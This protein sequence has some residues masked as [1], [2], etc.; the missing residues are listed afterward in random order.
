MGEGLDAVN[1]ENAKSVDIV[2]S[3]G[4]RQDLDPHTA[5]PGSLVTCDNLEFDQLGRLA[6]R[7]G[8]V[9]LGKTAISK[10]FTLSTQVRR[11]AQA[12]DG[13][14]LI[15][16]E[17]DAFAYLP[18]QDKVTQVSADGDIWQV[19]IH[20]SMTDVNGIAG[21]NN[22]GVKFCDSISVG[23]WAVYVYIVFD[24]VG[25]AYWVFADVIDT[26]SGAHVLARVLLGGAAGNY[27]PRL[28]VSGGSS[29]VFALWEDASTTTIRYARIDLSTAPFVWGAS[30]AFTT[31]S[32]P[33][34]FDAVQLNSGWAFV[35]YDTS[36]NSAVVNSYD[37]TPAQQHQFIWL[38]NGGALNW[39]PTA[40]TISGNA[41]F[42][43]SNIR[44]V[45]YDPATQF[46]ESKIL[47][48]TL[49]SVAS[50]RINPG[51][52]AVKHVRQLASITALSG[53]SYIA[54]SNY[55]SNTVS[56]NPR[57]HLYRY[58]LGDTGV[59]TA[60][61]PVLANYSLAS[62]FYMDSA[63]RGL[64]IY[65]FAR[66]DDPSGAQS[67]FLMLGLGTSVSPT[68]PNALLHF[69]SGRLPLF[70]DNA[71]TGIGGIV[72]LTS[73]RPG[74]FQFVAVTNIGASQYSGNQVQSWSF[75]S[76]GTQRYLAAEVQREVVVGGGSPLIFDGQRFTELSFYSYPVMHS[77]NITPFAAGGSMAQGVYQ[78]RA[79]FEW[80]DAQ[81]NRH[82]SP[83][84]PAI[85]VDLSSATYVAGTNSVAFSLPAMQ[86]TRKQGM[87]SVGNPAVS[88]VF[89]RTLAGGAVFYRVPGAGQNHTFTTAATTFTDTYADAS[90]SGN[91]PIYTTGGGQGLLASTAPP[92]S[93]VLTT[94]AGRLWGVDC[95]NP[96]RIWCTRTLQPGS[97]P[98]YNPGLQILIPGAGRINGLGGQDG[99]LYALA[100]NGIYLASYGDGP[101]D[102]GAGAFPSPELIT[103]TAN[104]QDPRGVLVGQD[105]IFFTGIDQWGTGVYLIRR[106]DGTPISIGKRVRNELA[107]FPVCR[108]V[109]NRTGKSRTEFLFV[110]S[111]TNPT[112]GAILNYHHDYND[113]EGIGQWTVTRF[114]GGI[115]AECIGVWDDITVTADE[116]NNIGWQTIGTTLDGGAVSPVTLIE[117]TDIRPA[118]LLGFAQVCAVSMLGTQK[119]ADPIE[120]EFSYDSGFSWPD[121]YQ[122]VA[123]TE[124]AGQPVIRRRE[125]VTQKQFDGSTI[126]VRLTNPTLGGSA[127]G[128]TYFHGIAIEVAGLGGNA[129]LDNARRA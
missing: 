18:A 29:I 84:A 47:S 114:P 72:D 87:S 121:T 16:S 105:G 74:L 26:V 118:G 81:S 31:T 6:K 17:D 83:A 20:A 60:F 51:L 46:L 12:D 71:T 90:I 124:S 120:I 66:F 25:A 55:T 82:Q 94:H 100:T 21:D 56:T 4:V 48:S 70:G 98:A 34:I 62:R 102:T 126:R 123:S 85:T 35:Y 75:Q 109:V 89:Y 69:A 80:T 53:S 73:K 79:V 95:E 116:S 36:T 45:G 14:R 110:D 52:G 93:I 54:F 77:G 104:C 49:T 63:A 78:Y 129:R 64:Y 76:L 58:T 30:T 13:T 32:G 97:A 67:H 103:T 122:W 59:F 24:G 38:A 96:E 119:S 3:R 33:C 86:A 127:P 128:A 39:T 91:E 68:V 1:N 43:S 112:A 106:G 61:T 10:S 44:V 5:P 50:G 9:T 15:F 37:S 108:G 57:G 11:F 88:V 40:L 22:G 23:T 111:D 117:T 107:A 28:V 8:F 125:P 99:K 65:V 113:E 92:P 41:V 101:D 19:A 2:F 27:P 7:D 115:P 42:T